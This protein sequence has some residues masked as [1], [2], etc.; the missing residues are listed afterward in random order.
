MS[1]NCLLEAGWTAGE[2]NKMEIKSSTRCAKQNG[3]T[4]YVP[5]IHTWEVSSLN[6]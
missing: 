5:G 1:C 2:Q 3:D 6:S 4:E